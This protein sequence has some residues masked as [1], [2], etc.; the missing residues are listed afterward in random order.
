MKK[1][2]LILFIFNFTIL[3]AAPES[4]LIGYWDQ[5]DNSN[6]E[7]IDHEIWARFLEKYLIEIDDTIRVRYGDVSDSDKNFL[8]RYIQYLESVTV[9]Q[10]SRDEQFPYWINLY[11]ALTVKVILDNYPVK[12]IKNIKPGG[13]FVSGPWDENYLTIE[14]LP[15]SLNSIEHGIL[16][17]IWGDFRVHYAVNCASMGCPPLQREVYTRDNVEYLLTKAERE[18]L[19]SFHGV[20]LQGTTLVISSIF[21][22]FRDDFGEREEDV[23]E[24]IEENNPTI[25]GQYKR[26]KYSYDWDINSP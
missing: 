24:Y 16:R 26:V 18:F 23:L 2:L 6:E 9:T 17:P 3:L 20:R 1:T 5:S 10:L 25:K 15:I 4:Q 14:G 7:Y 21:K 11:N 12:S 8:D 13:L 22:W 19:N